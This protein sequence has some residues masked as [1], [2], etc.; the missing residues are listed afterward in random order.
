MKSILYG[1]LFLCFG[2]YA[3]QM[4]LP[5]ME[6]T[7]ACAT[8]L[9]KKEDFKLSE[10]RMRVIGVPCTINIEEDSHVIL[11]SVVCQQN[12]FEQMGVEKINAMILEANDKV[13]HSLKTNHQYL[14]REIKMA[15]IPDSH[16]WSL[17][18]SFTEQDQQGT[19]TERLLAV[20]FDGN[21]K[22]AVMKRIL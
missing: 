21:G 4:A 16:D 17:T 2:G 10:G 3:Q 22:F 13:R 12:V 8:A 1:L 19:A 6:K 5:G 15:Y 11:V 18:N 7:A 14:P 9:L 20:D